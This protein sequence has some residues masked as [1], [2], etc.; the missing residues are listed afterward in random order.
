MSVEPA[1]AFIASLR[2][3]FQE[4][5]QMD[6]SQLAPFV[7][8]SFAPRHFVTGVVTLSGESSQGVI[9]LSFDRHLACHAAEL[10]LGVRCP[11][12]NDDVADAVGELTNIIAGSSRARMAVLH[13]EAGLPDVIRGKSRTIRFPPNC[14]TI[15]VPMVAPRGELS[16][17]FGFALFSDASAARQARKDL[18]FHAASGPL[19]PSA[20]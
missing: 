1:K 17:D 15:C 2:H 4:M 14:Q 5:L 11:E 7:N 10:L 13:L 8:R 6:L 12:V 19:T 3:V 18:A 9:A 20:N 16:L